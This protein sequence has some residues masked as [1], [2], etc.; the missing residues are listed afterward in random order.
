MRYTDIDHHIGALASKQHGAFSRQQA[1]TI[2]ASER[3][4]HRRAVARSG[5]EPA[6]GSW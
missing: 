4:V 1:F 6:L 2:G 5:N 3:F